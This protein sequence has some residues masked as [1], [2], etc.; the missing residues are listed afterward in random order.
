MKHA[1]FALYSTEYDALKAR[2]R[3]TLSNIFQDR[4]ALEETLAQK[5]CLLFPTEGCLF[6]FVPF[7]DVCHD[8]F[9]LAADMPALEDGLT[10]CL[11]HAD[12]PGPV[13]ASIIGKEPRAGLQAEVFQA[14]G[15]ALCKE[16]L[17]THLKKPK[18]AVIEAMRALVGNEQHKDISFA[19][20]GDEEEILAM[21]M[22]EFDIVG[23]NLPELATIR[24]D[25]A[26]RH[27]VVLRRGGHIA[28]LHY[29]QR[30]RNMLHSLYDVTRKEFRR[31]QLFTAISLFVHDVFEKEEG[32][33]V[34]AFG[35]RDISK[36]R[37]IR[38]AKMND[39]EMDGVHVYNL[40]YPSTAASQEK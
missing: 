35:W 15:F 24:N 40:L 33:P 26:K 16:L 17:R 25:I 11:A 38:H 34:R 30:H 3:C 2:H 31:E 39:Q 21:L 32:K 7:H 1:T 5:D 4:E 36:K 28:S 6:L 13:R 18:P 27:I 20:P 23:D 10:R 14:Q 19:V 12:L 37:L 8:C 29:F 22:E 9:Y